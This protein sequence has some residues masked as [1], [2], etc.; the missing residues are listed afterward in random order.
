MLSVSTITGLSTM[1]HR[2]CA[3]ESNARYTARNSF[4]CVV[5]LYCPW[6]N[7]RDPNATG[8]Y[9]FVSLPSWSLV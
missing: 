7:L 6:V 8:A 5:R 1:P 4:A 9:V 3:N 2:M